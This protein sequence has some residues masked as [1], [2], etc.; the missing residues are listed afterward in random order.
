MPKPTK[1]QICLIVAAVSFFL[2]LP[3]AICVFMFS[4]IKEIKTTSNYEQTP[5][6]N[7]PR[8]IS[9]AFSQDHNKKII[10]AHLAITSAQKNLSEGK[11]QAAREEI[12]VARAIYEDELGADNIMVCTALSLAADLEMKEHNY[13][14]AEKY[15]QRIVEIC[16]KQPVSR[17]SSMVRMDLAQA[18]YKNNDLPGAIAV[19]KESLALQ[20]KALGKNSFESIETLNQLGEYLEKN[21]QPRQ[22]QSLLERGLAIATAKH[23]VAWQRD[24]YSKLGALYFNT[25]R[26]FEAETVFQKL[27]DISKERTDWK[28]YALQ[29]LVRNEI[30]NKDFDKIIAHVNEA[31]GQRELQEQEHKPSKIFDYYA[32][33]FA[34]Y[35]K[36]MQSEY[37]ANLDTY[38]KEMAEFKSEMDYGSD[39]IDYSRSFVL[40]NN[41]QA[42][43]K[44]VQAVIDFDQRNN[45]D[46]NQHNYRD[47]SHKR[48][49]AQLLALAQENEEC[50][51]YLNKQT[52]TQKNVYKSNRKQIM[53][54]LAY[55]DYATDLIAFELLSGNKKVAQKIL[56]ELKANGGE[57]STVSTIYVRT[58]KNKSKKM[59]GEDF[60]TFCHPE[61]L[62]KILKAES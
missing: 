31:L 41:L 18:K 22:A 19:L 28:L 61:F 9:R 48:D 13:Q 14:E 12:E 59:D 40:S 30:Q 37:S 21:N 45:S 36:G 24:S 16:K 10:K 57:L 7:W 35:K 1:T 17:Y 38:L 32:L 29:Q 47:I 58:L 46:S 4:Q 15:N 27:Y 53:A 49:Y 2:I 5:N 33:A 8:L 3:I 39:Q 55:Q 52:E 23:S 34:Y 26:W 11:M 62:D 50:R 51:D 60:G 44:M 56:S 54:R 6:M 43:K 20:E 42:A 25:G